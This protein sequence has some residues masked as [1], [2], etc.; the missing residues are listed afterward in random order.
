MDS[1]HRNFDHRT[2]ANR[3]ALLFLAV[4]AV[5]GPPGGLGA[6]EVPGD[7]DWV[8]VLLVSG[9]TVSG[10]VVSTAPGGLLLAMGD[11]S[12]SGV[13]ATRIRRIDRLA[14]ERRYGGR[15]FL[16]TAG[17]TGTAIGLVAAA[18][19][20]PCTETGM[21]A[22]FLHP[23]DEMGA[24]TQGFLLGGVLLGI[25]A[26]IVVALIKTEH[27]EEAALPRGRATSVSR[28]SR[29]LPGPEG[30]SALHLSDA[31]LHLAPAPGGGVRAGVSIPI[32]R[33]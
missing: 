18:T 24:F 5:A 1:P 3:I 21:F 20:S 10:A 15:G 12:T 14:G 9:E 29:P 13:P 7:G 23:R 27:W 25:P 17:V 11:G 8:R 31:V 26:G 16:V 19:W 32:G 33:R 28:G 4:S 22:C 6:Q 2:F 30:G